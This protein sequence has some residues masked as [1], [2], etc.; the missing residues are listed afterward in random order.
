VPKQEELVIRQGKVV[1]ALNHLMYRVQMD[2]GPEILCYSSGKVRRYRIRIL[3][4]DRVTVE[5]SPHDLSR[6]RIVYRH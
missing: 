1:E 3:V 5:L 2:E 4:G 6:G